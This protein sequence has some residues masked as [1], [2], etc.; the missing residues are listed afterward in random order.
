MVAAVLMALGANLDIRAHGNLCDI[1]AM[2]TPGTM[3]ALAL[4]VRFVL[5]R[6]RNGS[7][8][9]VGQHGREGPPELFFNGIEVSVTAR[10]RRFIVAEGMT[11]ET[12]FAVV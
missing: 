11:D 9:T 7:P 4:N 10:G 3:A 5:E 6:R 2:R 12:V 1:P 8:V